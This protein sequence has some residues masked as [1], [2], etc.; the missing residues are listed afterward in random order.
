MAE[1][2]L[3]VEC[4]N[5]HPNP[6]DAY[7]CATCA[8]SLAAAPRLLDNPP[9]MVVEA[10]TG[11]RLALRRDLVVGRAPQYLSYNEGTE[12]LTV[13]S[14][15]RLVS[16]SHVLLQVVGWQVSAIDM[17]SHNGTVLRRLGYEDVQLVPD[18]QVPLRYGDEL[19]LGDGVVLRFLPP[20]AST[21]D[22]AAASAHSAGESLNV[23]GSLTY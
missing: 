19:D 23:T 7:D 15:G 14:P 12:L 17:D 8:G 3:G 2:L 16:R 20:G 21:D 5:G 6:P 1:E 22:A 4:V 13:P 18:A 9:R 11:A 10:S